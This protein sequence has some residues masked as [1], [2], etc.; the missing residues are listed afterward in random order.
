MIK[1]KLK[2][3]LREKGKTMTW[4]HEQTGISKN[5]LSLM[6]NN[7]SKGIQFDTLEKICITMDITPND[8]IEIHSDKWYIYAEK[9]PKKLNNGL[10]D[11]YVVRVFTEKNLSAFD[12][13]DGITIEA[14]AY[15]PLDY[16]VFCFVTKT[17]K[18]YKIIITTKEEHIFNEYS[19]ETEH[20]FE[21][22]AKFFNDLSDEEQNILIKDIYYFLLKTLIPYD[23]NIKFADIRVRMIIDSDWNPYYY[24]EIKKTDDSIEL[25]DVETTFQF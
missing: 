24:K 10:T 13:G 16:Q 11:L 8:L 21:D 6:A 9:S 5:T 2:K 3:I 1:V 19:E 15:P 12:V 23:E 25:S 22:N 18:E 4:L 14:S 7:S 17:Q 20:S